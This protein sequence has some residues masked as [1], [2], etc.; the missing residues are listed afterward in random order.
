MY[1]FL[2]VFLLFSY[3]FPLPFQKHFCPQRYNIELII[4]RLQCQT[5]KTHCINL[6]NFVDAPNFGS[7]NGNTKKVGSDSKSQQF[8]TF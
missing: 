8:S 4:G 7:E 6:L 3:S 2:I 1:C 5:S